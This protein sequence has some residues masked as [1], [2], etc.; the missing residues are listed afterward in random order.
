[1]K[2]PWSITWASSFFPVV[3]AGPI[4][5]PRQVADTGED[6]GLEDY[7]D[8]LGLG[9]YRLLLGCLQF[10]IAAIFKW[11]SALMEII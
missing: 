6:S 8:L 10:V 5:R 3:S 2:C 4:G 1:M 9:S 7:W 11:L